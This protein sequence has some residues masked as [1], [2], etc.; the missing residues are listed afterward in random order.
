M[1]ES[2]TLEADSRLS[3]VESRQLHICEFLESE[4]LHPSTAVSV[5]NRPRFD[6]AQLAQVEA[7]DRMLHT[8]YAIRESLRKYR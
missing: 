1:L 3:R 4:P 8:A 5:S 6:L 7:R 2:L